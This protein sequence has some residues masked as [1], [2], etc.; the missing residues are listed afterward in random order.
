MIVLVGCERSGVVRRAFRELGHNA[1]S[2]DLAPADDGDPHHEQCDLLDLV[3]YPHWDLLIA[4]PECRYLS[5]SGLHWTA[6]KLR[7]LEHTENA[8]AFVFDLIDA[9]RHI[10]RVCIENSR[11]LLSRV[12]RAPDQTLQPYE[13]GHDASKAT[14][15]WLRN[16]PLLKPTKHIAPR[17]VNGR[18]RWA[19]QS[20]GGQNRL[21]PSPMRSAIR[22]ETY[23]GI[24]AAMADQWGNL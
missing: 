18:P 21:S 2:C 14:D 13:Y 10:R 22:A 24:A 23:P 7:P 15:L 9:S 6:R 1:W 12:L 11:G 20:D 17:I 8:I 5:A 4:H 3:G 16:L 19:N